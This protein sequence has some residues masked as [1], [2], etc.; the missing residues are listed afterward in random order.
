MSDLTLILT[1]E[2]LFCFP[3]RIKGGS[4]GESMDP[5]PI[6][7]TQWKF[8]VSHPIPFSSLKCHL[9]NR[10]PNFNCNSYNSTPIVEMTILHYS[11]CK[12]IVRKGFWVLWS[13]LYSFWVSSSVRPPTDQSRGGRITPIFLVYTWSPI[14]P[15]CCWFTLHHETKPRILTFFVE[16]IFRPLSLYLVP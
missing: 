9:L 14:T 1:V 16:T 12:D 11:S 5:H 6:W 15:L 10:F 4:G 2:F 3:L 7:I 13:E 8:L